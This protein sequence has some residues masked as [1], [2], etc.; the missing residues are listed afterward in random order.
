MVRRAY[1]TVG[2]GD[3]LSVA[4]VAWIHSL[5]E[6]R[7]RCPSR[8]TEDLWRKDR[9]CS[10]RRPQTCQDNP[11]S[12]EGSSHRSPDEALAVSRMLKHGPWSLCAT[13]GTGAPHAAELRFQSGAV[14][15]V[16]DADFDTSDRRRHADGTGTDGAAR[17]GSARPA[18]GR[19]F[20]GP[21]VGAQKLHRRL[22][23]VRWRPKRAGA[24]RRPCL[25][26]AGPS[27][28]WHGIPARCHA[29]TSLTPRPQALSRKRPR[30]AASGGAGRASF[31]GPRTRTAHA[32][33]RGRS[34]PADAGSWA[35]R[36]SSGF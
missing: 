35:Y 5:P 29:A 20:E 27:R 14:A 11:D 12:A 30:V 1:G 34:A 24:R 9:A 7:R 32:P 13:G 4:G 28:R 16:T 31:P 17:V 18:G 10:R 2:I 8:S 26:R 19:R 33:S 21:V 15:W 36:A 22:G 23:A 3:R 6:L 25:G